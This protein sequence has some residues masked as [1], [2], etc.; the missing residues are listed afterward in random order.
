MGPKRRTTWPGYGYGPRNGPFQSVSE[1][2]LA[3]SVTPELFRLIQP[4]RTIYSGAPEIDPLVAPPEA[5]LALRGMT[6]DRQRQDQ[7]QEANASPR[8]GVAG[9]IDTVRAGRAFAIKSEGALANGIAFKRETI[10][11][12]TGDDRNP[13]WIHEWHEARP[14]RH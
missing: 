12:M 4:A 2:R 14:S 1:L 5:L 11:R 7:S 9:M 13:F 6:S 3:I 10:V 8:S